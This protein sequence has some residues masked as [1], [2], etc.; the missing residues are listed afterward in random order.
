LTE[1]ALEPLR[2]APDRAAILS[3]VDGT[4]AP[5]AARPEQAAVPERARAALRELARSYALVGCVSGRRAA[6]ARDLVGVDE[7][8]YVGN[9]GLERLEPG[10]EEPTFDPALGGREDLAREVVATLDHRRLEAVGIRAEDKGPIQALHWRGAESLAAA[11]LEAREAAAL[12]QARGL[13]PHWGRKVLELR[14]LAEV[15]KGSVIERLL[16]ELAPAAALYGGDDITDLDGFDG[17]RRLAEAG[18]IEHAV[19]VGVA[20]DEGPA[21]LAERADLVVEGTD[22]FIS[23]LE[24]LVDPAGSGSRG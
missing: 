14:P 24:Q 15:D 9:H 3:D 21:A 1:A 20:S 18:T 2:A 6:E 7:L 19:C 8:L 23:L 4:L 16:G 5:I 10:A 12:A 22:G 13:H 17:L 11:E